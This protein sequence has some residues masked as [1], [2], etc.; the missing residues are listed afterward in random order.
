[1]SLRGPVLVAALAF[2]AGA[3][4]APATG[5]P[6]LRVCADPNALPYSNERREGFENAIVE[7]IARDLGRPVRYTWWAQRR[8][9]LRLTLRAGECDVVA[10]VPATY[11]L[12]LNTAPYYRSTYVFVQRADAPHPVRSLDDPA[13]RQLRVGVQLV[14]ADGVNTPP[15]HALT[16]RGIVDN[17]RGYPVYGDYAR[18]SPAAA[19]VTAVAEGELDVA[20][21]WGPVAG[22]FA[23]RARVPLATTP[24][25][26]PPEP[27]LAFAFDIAMG[28]RKGDAAL[29]DALDAALARRRGDIARI[30]DTYGIPRDPATVAP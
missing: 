28:V 26:P 7:L 17:V 12:T 20:L 4:A 8:G 5:P 11:E 30:L 23:R 9:F 16:S 27:P 14:G 25:V 15:A 2:A 22:Y 18:T 21:V 3:V 29:R 19:V 10:S 24:L 1:V 6:E 13:L